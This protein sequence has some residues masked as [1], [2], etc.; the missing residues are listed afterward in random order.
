MFL[1]DLLLDFATRPNPQ[2]RCRFLVLV[3]Y[4]VL[5]KYCYL[6]FFQNAFLH[7]VVHYF[8]RHNYLILEQS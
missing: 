6:F 2:D 8:V 7:V 4:F 1:L 5:H 3:Y